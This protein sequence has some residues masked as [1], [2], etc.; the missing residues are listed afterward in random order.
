MQWFATKSA[1]TCAMVLLFGLCG[2]GRQELSAGTLP[3][4]VDETIP[5]Q[6]LVAWWTEPG[7]APAGALDPFLFEWAGQQGD[8]RCRPDRN[9][10]ELNLSRVLRQASISVNNARSM[11][12]VLGCSRVLMG[13]LEPVDG[14]VAV[15]WLGLHRVG[16]R[17]RARLVDVDRGSVVY[18]FERQVVAMAVEPQGARERALELLSRDLVRT[19][20]D[21]H[22]EQ[23][24]FT[25]VLEPG[26]VVVLSGGDAEGYVTLLSRLAEGFGGANAVQEVWATEGRLGVRVRRSADVTVDDFL[27]ALETM[28]GEP[29]GRSRI[30]RVQRDGDTVFVVVG[31][32]GAE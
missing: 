22:V 15:P 32:S 3:L 2:A 26:M 27:S 10:G 19:L 14:L 8:G 6:E 7:G 11:A 23:A 28:D 17:L 31:R 5:G 18:Q 12:S 21:L 30:E 29:L 9:P 25:E 20:E 13:R 1:F 24:R 16:L 4:V